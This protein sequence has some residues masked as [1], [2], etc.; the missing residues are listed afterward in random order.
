VH[1]RLRTRKLTPPGPARSCRLKRGGS[2]PRVAAWTVRLSAGATT[3]P[4]MSMSG[5]A[6]PA[7]GV[8]WH[9]NW[10]RRL[11]DE[12][13]V[14]TTNAPRAAPKKAQFEPCGTGRDA[15]T[16][17]PTH[18]KTAALNRSATHPQASSVKAC[19]ASS[20]NPSRYLGARLPPLS[21]SARPSLDMNLPGFLLRV[22]IP[23]TLGR[24]YCR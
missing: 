17:L 12:T 13:G 5:S 20:S 18:F 16:W 4:G 7:G 8:G 24:Q 22:R 21:R 15:P 9:P 3:W 6:G 10:H 14:G 23:D 2:L 11:R 1:W 19:P